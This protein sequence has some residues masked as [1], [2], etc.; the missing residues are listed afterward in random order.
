[1][2]SLEVSNTELLPL[3]ENQ[4]SETV[5]IKTTR[6][7]PSSGVLRYEESRERLGLSDLSKR[8]GLHHDVSAGLTEALKGNNGGYGERAREWDLLDC[9][10]EEPAQ[11][12]AELSYDF[13]DYPSTEGGHC[14]TEAENPQCVLNAKFR[15]QRFPWRRV[16]AT[17]VPQRVPPTGSPFGSRFHVSEGRSVSPLQTVMVQ[18]GE[19]N[20]LVRVQMDLFGTRHLIKAADLTLGTAG[21]RPTRIY[22]QNH[23]VLF[24][25]GLHECGSRLQMAGDFLVY[26]THLN[27]TPQYHG[28]VI[29]RTNGAVVPIECHYFR[30]GNVSSNP[31]KPTWIPFS[32]TKSGE[33]HLSFSLRLMNDDWLTERTS[34]VYYLGDLIHIE[35]S[36]SMTNHMPLKLYIDH[37]VATL[38]P[39]KDSSQRY[40]I[41]DYNGCL[42]DSKAED[43]F[44]TFVLPR[45]ER[46]LDKLRFDLD[47][48]RFF[49]DDR[50]LIFIT[51]HL[52]V[53]A[54]D[55]RDSMNKACTFQKMQNVWTPLEESNNDICACCHVGNCGATREFRF[56]SR[57]R[58]DLSEAGL[59]WEGEASL[60]PLLILDTEVTDLAT[61]SLNEVE[62][63]LQARSP[64]GVKSEVVLIV[65]LT[66]TA[67]CLISA[68]LIALFL[69]RKRKQTPVLQ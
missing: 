42:L 2:T 35:A 16:K 18:C 26:T 51:C 52:K 10:S 8:I 11:T 57:G 7:I 40:S 29:V 61:E 68:S 27:H 45:D 32:S 34:T 30:K 69:Y 17:P 60:G 47:A 24:D 43:S 12:R 13:I 63:R 19:Q 15:D 9:T 1:M 54:V 5:R 6:W 53:A 25:Y 33:G 66:V 28:S 50:S 46:E 4:T 62:R 44:S 31:I 59:K 58:R 49:G 23:T 48:F 37:C 56:L 55:R 20:L 39:D 36:V 14:A 64:G 3:E 65:A 67:V 41:I 21:C 38:S 22:S